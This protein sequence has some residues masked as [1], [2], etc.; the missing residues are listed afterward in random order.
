MI[1]TETRVWFVCSLW[2]TMGSLLYLTRLSVLEINL[3]RG[4][5]KGLHVFPN[6]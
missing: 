6:E 5:R 4:K 3:A 2:Q 1:D